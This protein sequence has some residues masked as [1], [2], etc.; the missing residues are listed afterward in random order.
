MPNYAHALALVIRQEVGADWWRTAKAF[1][2][3][4]KPNG[5]EQCEHRSHDPNRLLIGRLHADHNQEPTPQDG[6]Q[7]QRTVPS[8]QMPWPHASPGAPPG[9]EA[10]RYRQDIGD[11]QENDT[12]RRDR[13]I[14]HQDRKHRRGHSRCPDAVAWGLGPETDTAQAG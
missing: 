7:C 3:D 4:A 6:N 14:W 11:I 5:E 2:L 12:N 13:R 8:P 9:D 1:P 10:R